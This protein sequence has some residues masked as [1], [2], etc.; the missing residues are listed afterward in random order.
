M[1]ELTTL[2]WPPLLLAYPLNTAGANDV[3]TKQEVTDREKWYSKERNVKRK[4]I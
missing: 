3:D 1:L 2:L 4:E